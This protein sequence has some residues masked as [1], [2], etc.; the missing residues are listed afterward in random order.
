MN[1]QLAFLQH[2]YRGLKPG[3]RAAVVLPDN[4]LFEDGQGRSIRADLMDKCNLHTILRLPT[5]IF[6]AQGVKTNV[7]FLQRGL[8][9]K[10]NTKQVWIYDMRTNMPAFGKRIPLVKLHFKDF[11][12]AYGNDPN[13]GSA[14]TDQGEAR[15]FRCFSRDAITER[16]ENL[17]ISWLRDESL[18]SGDGLPEPEIIGANIME[19]LR[20]ASKEMETLM[21]LLE[22]EEAAEAVS[23]SVGLPTLE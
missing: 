8:T 7:L 16:N 17:D 18:Q 12:A 23:A 15:R 19:K 21:V 4:V 11:E 13:G 1:K 9:E 6:Y 14:R 22:G 5:G 20:V 10:G 3:G 2:I